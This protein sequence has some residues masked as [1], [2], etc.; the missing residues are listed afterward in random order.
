MK[1]CS[2]A[3]LAGVVA[4]VE[5]AQEPQ[6]AHPDRLRAAVQHDVEPHRLRAVVACGDDHAVGL[7]RAVHR[8]DEAAEHLALLRR[9]RASGRRAARRRVRGRAERFLHQ[10]DVIRCE[11]G[12]VAQ[13]PDDAF[14]EHL[15]VG[16]EVES[17][18]FRAWRWL[19]RGVWLSLLERLVRLR[20]NCWRS[21]AETQRGRI[22]P[23]REPVLV[24]PAESC[25]Q[26]DNSP[27]QY[28]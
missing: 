9:P 16:E 14:V 2:G 21:S 22:R 15:G 28:H 17:L 5:A 24:R 25:P 19:T 23:A 18:R 20:S 6:L 10:R 8:G 27:L 7:H 4:L 11:V 13:R 12:L 26:I 1:S 3:A